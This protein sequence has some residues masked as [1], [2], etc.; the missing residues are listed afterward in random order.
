[1]YVKD[2]SVNESIFGKRFEMV[3]EEEDFKAEVNTSK[4]KLTNSVCGCI[5]FLFSDIQ[6]QSDTKL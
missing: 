3:T 5:I 2:L 4:I 6:K 1:M